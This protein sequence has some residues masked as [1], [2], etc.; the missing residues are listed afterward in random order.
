MQKITDLN[1]FRRLLRAL[2]ISGEYN[3][4]E[5]EADRLL[6]EKPMIVVNGFMT[7]NLNTTAVALMM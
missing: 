4:T 5:E 3:L 7:G 1:E 2:L 6:N